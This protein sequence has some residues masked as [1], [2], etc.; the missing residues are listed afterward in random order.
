MAVR[1]QFTCSFFRPLVRASNS[2]RINMGNLFAYQP[3]ESAA[4]CKVRRLKSTG[5]K[6]ITDRCRSIRGD[7]FCNKARYFTP[8]RVTDISNRL[9]TLSDGFVP[10]SVPTLVPYN[11]NSPI[12]IVFEQGSREHDGLRN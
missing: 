1:T 10:P 4:P 12:N 8:Y 2:P 11:V 7:Y 3:P 9:V 5:V 6:S